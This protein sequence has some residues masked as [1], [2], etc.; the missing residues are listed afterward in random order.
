MQDVDH[1]DEQ[2]E[3]HEESALEVKEERLGRT[4]AAD[5]CE[6]LIERGNSHFSNGEPE[7]AKACFEN[8]IEVAQNGGYRRFEGMASASLGELY[9]TLQGN[10]TAIRYYS[11]ALEIAIENSD[12]PKQGSA[13]AGLAFAYLS[14]EDFD[15]A[16]K[17]FL[18]CLSVTDRFSVIDDSD[19]QDEVY[20]Y[21]A[22]VYLSQRK[23]A[24][25]IRYFKLCLTRSQELQKTESEATFL[26]HLGNV[27]E[28]QG[29]YHEALKHYNARLKIVW[30]VRDWEAVYKTYLKLT[31][32]YVRLQQPANAKFVQ[33]TADK[34]AKDFPSLASD[35]MEHAGS[36][37]GD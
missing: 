6:E 10:D 30:R 16:E 13:Y 15:N 1:Q 34:L 3:E 20:E 7:E 9:L 29:N 24:K 26:S 22:I 32:V 2:E 28:L 23:H 36:R 35:A 33:E 21:L 25:A 18:K 14:K 5:E 8:V 37:G 12:M 11:I 4:S 27:C 17:N 31:Q 19:T